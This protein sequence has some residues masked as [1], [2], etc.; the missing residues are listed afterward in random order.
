MVHPVK[1]IDETLAG[2]DAGAWRKRLAR[3]TEEHGTFEELGASH[4]SCL[5]EDGTTLLVTF[6]TEQDIRALDEEA[7]PIGWEMVKSLGWSS[8]ALI[9][10]GETWFRDDAVYDHVDR[11][12]DDGFFDGFERV[13]FYGAG[14]C[15]YAAAAFSV[16]AP[17]AT[18]LA[19]QP[20]ATLTPEIAG[21]DH[22]FGAARAR[23]FT[24]RFG[25]APDMI[26]AC[27]HC[28]LVYDPLVALDAMH[29]ALFTRPNV[30]KLPIRRIGAEAQT[31][32]MEMQVLHRLLARAG[33]G[34]LSRP[35]FARL[36]RARRSHPPYLSHLLAQ[37]EAAGRD[38]LA[39]RLCRNVSQRMTAPRF[40]RRMRDLEAARG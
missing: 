34:Q 10:D 23:D 8:L 3:I 26:D 36:M 30:T 28:F 19:I 21:W 15:G 17:G 11:M 37:L 20:Q 13:L 14:S 12:I 16:A 9:G 2:L 25:Y 24:T 39:L 18:V 33:N 35:G 32:M 31:R 4:V 38:D 6:E 1:M 29:A 40:E 27:D 5:I 22:R 7:Q